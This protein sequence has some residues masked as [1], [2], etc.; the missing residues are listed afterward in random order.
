MYKLSERGTENNRIIGKILGRKI[1]VKV[2]VKESKSETCRKGKASAQNEQY[3]I[4]HV[5]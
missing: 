2:I 3:V 1:F 4:F 5:C